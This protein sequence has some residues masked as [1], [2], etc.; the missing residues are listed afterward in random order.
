M[1]FYKRLFITALIGLTGLGSVQAEVTINRADAISMDA[2]S[3]DKSAI[4][5]NSDIYIVQMKG[6][7][8]IAY[9]GDVKGYQATKPGKGKKLNPNSAHVKKYAAFL[10]KKQSKVVHSVGAKQVYSYRY[11]INGFAARMTSADAERLRK[12]P[13][14][15]NVWKDEIRKL[16]TDSS[17]TYIGVTESGQA[18]SKGLTGEDVVIGIIDTGVWPEHPSFADVKT[19]KKGNKGP[20]IAYDPIGDFYPSGCDFGNT[21][22]NPYDAPFTCN[23]KLLSSRCFNSG[24]SNGPDGSNPCGGDGA[25]TA[26]WEFQSG[27][28][29][30]G[31]GSHTASTSGGNNDVPAYL[32]GEYQG[33]ISGV[34]PR[35][36]LASYKVCWDGPD[37]N[38]NTDDGCASSDSA[39]AIDW[40]VY[41]GVDVI[42]FSIGGSSNSFGGA[43][44]VAFLFAA[45]AGVH[46]ATSNGN[47]GPGAGTVGT[48]S[49]VPWITAVGA[50][51]DDG[52]YYAN[53]DVH[54]PGSIAGSYDAVEGAGDV[55]FMDTGSISDDVTL[56]STVTACDADGANDPIS[57]IALVAR[58]VCS[59]TQKY[60]NVM[61]AGA[62]AIIVYTYTGQ[63]PITMSAP[64]TGIPGVM[65]TYD[66][67]VAMAAESGVTAT[68]GL[69]PASN[70][71]AGFSSRGPNNGAL[72]II[73]PDVSAPGVKILA[74]VSPWGAGGE[75]FGNYNGT[76][77]AS[78]HTAG[79][80][81][82]LKQAHPDWSP[83]MSRSALMTTARNG[84]KK[85]FGED[86]ADP[87][88]VGA[89]EILPS[90]AVDPGLAYDVGLF[91]YAAFSCENNVQIF[92]DASC[93]FLESLG[94]PSDGSDLNLPSIGIGD[95]AGSQTITRTVTAVY[96]NSG[97][98]NFTVSV[99]APPGVDVSVSPS[100]FSL[101]KGDSISYEVTFVLNEGAAINEWAFGSLTWTDD[102]ENYSVRSPIAVYPTVFSYPDQVNGVADGNGDGSVDVEIGFGYEGVY[103]AAVAGIEASGGLDSNSS[104]AFPTQAF[105]GDFPAMPHFRAALF[106]EET[107]DPGND[108]LDLEVFYL[109]NGCGDFAGYQ[110][111]GGSYTPTTEESVD[112]ANG[113]A[114]GYHVQVYYF[115]ASNGD[116]SDYTLWYQPVFGDNG[117]TTVTAPASAEFG[118]AT[119]TVDYTG[120]APTRNLGVLIHSDSGG[121]MGRT[122]LSIDGR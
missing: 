85:S 19:H 46:V 58:G 49:G 95:L 84:L 89:G 37:P 41:D 79:A 73:K 67:G 94:V 3:M 11:A 92:S 77:M 74:A 71:I 54:T 87:F 117:N 6:N 114:G 26:P 51:N 47:S 70:R 25:F 38:T 57:G 40:A 116:N 68:V 119:V 30:D 24:F 111:L 48:P 36:R 91:E 82:L 102:D 13:E 97:S 4:A 76:S 42:N 75:E 69:V 34:A 12:N 72:D 60:N 106:D 80:F 1:R 27:R 59:F 63:A 113:P 32:N 122:V 81:A 98:K 50:T 52:V 65:V 100:S 39:A 61:A 44:D 15:M 101:R 104:V 99:D 29:N 5:A 22:A 10:G 21:A 83:A 17:P 107:S 93:D 8:V 20:K 56:A 53:V 118:A 28:D 96:N 55:S 33:Q 16:Q 112:V 66:T 35:A 120:V 18:W 110:F 108:D 121:E 7:P 86:L 31:H 109:P 103:S 62:S 115:A 88:D 45:D 78:P 14:V 2:K 23:N 9:E 90:D 43:D 64:G 105:C